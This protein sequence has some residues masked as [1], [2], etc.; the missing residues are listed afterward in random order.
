MWSV[1]YSHDLHGNMLGLF[2]GPVNNDINFGQLYHNDTFVKKKQTR[3]FYDDLTPIRVNGELEYV[4][5]GLMG[6][7]HKPHIFVDFRDK[8][9][10]VSTLQEVDGS[11]QLNGA[12]RQVN[13]NVTSGTTPSTSSKDHVED[14]SGNAEN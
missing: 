14:A 11:P 8:S 10:Q 13:G 3:E 4:A 1:P 7:T 5:T 12:D 6:N 2:V 9:D